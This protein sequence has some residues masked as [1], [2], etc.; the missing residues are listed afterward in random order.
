M[1]ADNWA[2]CPKCKLKSEKEYTEQ[3]AYAK[4][5]YGVISSDEY[6]ELIIEAE[7]PVI[8]EESMRE[9]YEIGVESDGEFSVSYSCCCQTCGFLFKFKHEEKVEI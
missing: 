8:F 2:I 5:Q 3:L 7:K 1:S 4:S 9:D 6:R